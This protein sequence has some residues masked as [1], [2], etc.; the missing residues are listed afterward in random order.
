MVTEKNNSQI[1]KVIEF[2][3]EEYE[4]EQLDIEKASWTELIIH[5]RSIDD[6]EKMVYQL[7]EVLDLK[8]VCGEG[9]LCPI[10]PMIFGTLS[11]I[12]NKGPTE[13]LLRK[14]DKL[15]KGLNLPS[16]KKDMQL[17]S[18]TIKAAKEYFGF[19]GQNLTNL[20]KWTEKYYETKENILIIFGEMMRSAQHHS[21]VWEAKQE[22]HD[23]YIEL[24][25][26]VHEFE[27]KPPQDT[28]VGIDGHMSDLRKKAG[29]IS[30]HADKFA[31]QMNKGP[32]LDQGNELT[33]E[34]LPS[35]Y[36]ARKQ[37]ANAKKQKTKF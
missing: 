25:D 1:N 32:N 3:T 8:D 29:L 22:A 24:I 20:N 14:I 15:K 10:H 23:K 6:L 36:N 19:N 21:I 9:G 2:E 27:N 30:G 12:G 33:R 17:E 34:P 5:I 13:P 11:N 31:N 7:I 16:I 37:R 18:V 4:E 28:S 26:K 35:E